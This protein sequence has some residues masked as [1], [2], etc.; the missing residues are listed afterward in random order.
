M[1]RRIKLNLKNLTVKSFTTN[2][3]KKLSGGSRFT[4]ALDCTEPVETLFTC[5]S[6]D[7]YA[8]CSPCE[9]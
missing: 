2:E 4:F 7:P 6:A 5:D 8:D 1:K 3:D 9:L